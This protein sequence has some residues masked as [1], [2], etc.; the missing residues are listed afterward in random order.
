MLRSV[1][2]ESQIHGSRGCSSSGS[3]SAGTQG[4]GAGQGFQGHPQTPLS[5]LWG[6]QGSKDIPR[7]PSV[8]SG[9]LRAGEG[10]GAPEE[11]LRWEGGSGRTLALPARRCQ[12]LFWLTRK[13]DG[14]KGT[15]GFDFRTN[16]L[17]GRV[18]PALE[19]ALEWSQQGWKH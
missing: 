8:C 18:W 10:S 11:Q 4:S 15:L 7:P 6:S 16:F 3:H 2:A 13:G 14:L 1:G 9:V 19:E 17:T 5:L 12:T